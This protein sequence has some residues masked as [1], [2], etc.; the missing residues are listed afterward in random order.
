VPVDCA[1][2]PPYRGGVPLGVCRRHKPGLAQ[3]GTMTGLGTISRSPDRGW[4]NPD[5]G[6]FDM[7]SSEKYWTTK[8]I[9]VYLWLGL[10]AVT[11]LHAGL[12]LWAMLTTAQLPPG[13]QVPPAWVGLTLGASPTSYWLY[14]IVLGANLVW[15]IRFKG[16]KTYVPSSYPFPDFLY[17]DIAVLL[18]LVLWTFGHLGQSNGWFTL[19]D[20]MGHTLA[21]CAVLWVFQRGYI[22]GQQ[23]PDEETKEDEPETAQAVY[24]PVKATSPSASPVIAQPKL[25]PKPSGNNESIQKLLDYVGQNGQAKTGALAEAMGI[26]KRT[27][28]R[29]LNKLIAEGRLVREGNGQGAVYKINDSH[30]AD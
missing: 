15:E 12:T 6:R 10:W 4:H 28:I 2:P 21:T 16:T 24:S 25:A 5:Y 17:S 14:V 22:L 18:W 20:Q 29:T 3:C 11:I 30:K 23:N 26:P 8:K 7:S 27:M 9:S 13:Y 19:P 1:N